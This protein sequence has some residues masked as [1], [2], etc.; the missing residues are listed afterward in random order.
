MENVENKNA[1]ENGQEKKSTVAKWLEFIKIVVVLI[2][3]ISA[4]VWVTKRGPKGCV[5]D[6][7]NV[8]KK[9]YDGVKNLIGKK[10]ES[11]DSA[12]AC[13]CVAE[14]PVNNNGC[15]GKPWNNNRQNNSGYNKHNN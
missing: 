10:K 14:A 12:P 8:T 13:D 7:K 2:T 5:S 4:T 3:V 1:Q 11:V 15:Q 6:V 9:G